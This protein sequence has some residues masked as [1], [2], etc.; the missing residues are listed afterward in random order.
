MIERNLSI[1]E[2]Q[3]LDLFPLQ[4]G[5]IYYRHF[6]VKLNVFWFVKVYR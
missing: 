2:Q 3:R 5:Q 4:A 1:T 6:E